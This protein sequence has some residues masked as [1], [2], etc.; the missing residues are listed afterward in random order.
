MLQSKYCSAGYHVQPIS[1]ILGLQGKVVLQ[2]CDLEVGELVHVLGDAH[3]YV[4]H[5]EPLKEQL[6][7]VPR[8]FPVGLPAY[9]QMVNRMSYHKPGVLSS[10]EPALQ[11]FTC[12]ISSVQYLLN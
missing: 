1:C 6:K 2:V 12:P 10:S 8:P 9:P 5:V 11:A 7:N 3:V 4:N